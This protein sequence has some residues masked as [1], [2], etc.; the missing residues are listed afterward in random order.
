MSKTISKTRFWF[1]IFILIFLLSSTAKASWKPMFQQES[2]KFPGLGVLEITAQANEGQMPKV[3]VRDA[4]KKVLLQLEMGYTEEVPDSFQHYAGIEFKVLHIP[5]LPNPLLMI[6]AAGSGGSAAPYE[7]ALIGIVFGKI[8]LLWQDAVTQPDY[9]G[10]FVGDLG[11]NRGVGIARWTW[12]GGECHA[13]P[14]DEYFIELYLWNKEKSRFGVSQQFSIEE[15]KFNSIKRMG[16]DFPDQI[17]DFERI[18][19]RFKQ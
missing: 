3:V 2:V 5:G 18:W 6:V 10:F 11:K 8:D 1:F 17:G 12:R 14:P 19:N 7:V 4:A 15:K 13:C 9:G 16:L